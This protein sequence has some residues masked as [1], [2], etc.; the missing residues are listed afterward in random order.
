MYM[1]G[2]QYWDGGEQR[3]GRMG[4]RAGYGD[5]YTGWVIGGLYRVPTDLVK[6]RPQTAER[7]PDGPAGAGSGWSEAAA[8]PGSWTTH[9]STPGAS[10]ARFAVQDPSPGNTPPPG[11]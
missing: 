2:W 3:C 4:V 7:A 1:C 6:R 8:R 5:G 9:S 10:G 11:Q